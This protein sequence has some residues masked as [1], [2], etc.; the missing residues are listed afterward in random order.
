MAN[1]AAFLADQHTAVTLGSVVTWEG[2]RGVVWHATQDILQVLPITKGSTSIPLSLANE[3]ALHLP[4]S[5]GGWSIAYDELRRWP[6]RPCRVI[7]ELDERSLLKILTARR[8]EPP[9]IRPPVLGEPIRQ[10]A[11]HLP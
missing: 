9:P 1:V 5:L 2:E 11:V 10:T 6:R 4:V 7:G 3:V 8:S